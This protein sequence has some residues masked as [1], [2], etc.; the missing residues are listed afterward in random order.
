M[1]D[2]IAG[3]SEHDPMTGRV[4]GRHGRQGR[5]EAEARDGCGGLDGGAGQGG[6]WL[7]DNDDPSLSSTSGRVELGTGGSVAMAPTRIPSGQR[8]RGVL[9]LTR[10]IS[11][12]LRVRSFSA[13]VRERQGMTVAGRSRATPTAGLT[14]AAEAVSSPA[15]E[16]D[17]G[18]GRR[19][20]SPLPPR[21]RTA[22]AGD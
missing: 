19:R 16:A 21:R 5:R 20:S 13:D 11:L 4:P 12:L 8:H 14:R 6:R 1:A 2:R 9:C 3:R 7:E 10:R 18:S 15:E 22:A 17:C